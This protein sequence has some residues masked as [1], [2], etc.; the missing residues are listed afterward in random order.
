MKYWRSGWHVV[1]CY[2][3]L[4]MRQKRRKTCQK[5]KKT[6]FWPANEVP[7]TCSLVKI[8]NSLSLKLRENSLLTNT[9]WLFTLPCLDMHKQTH[10]PLADQSAKKVNSMT[11]LGV[12]ILKQA[13]KYWPMKIV[14]F[15][16]SLVP[17]KN[18]WFYMKIFSL[19]LNK[20]IRLTCI[21]W[22]CDLW[23][24]PKRIF[25]FCLFYE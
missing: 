22:F 25:H 18:D 10:N 15:I 1:I 24:P 5:C 4:K 14:F 21:G 7:C 20:T 9:S 2:F 6:R 8:Y 16:V 13:K 11:T 3:C 23:T 17:R 19:C 12:K